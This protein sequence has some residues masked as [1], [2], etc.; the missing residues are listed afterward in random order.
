[1][2]MDYWSVYD[3]SINQQP[4]VI[5]NKIIDQNKLSMIKLICQNKKK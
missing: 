2:K 5:A 3:N 1:M 4:I